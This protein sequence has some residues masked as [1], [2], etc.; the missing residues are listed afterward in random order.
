MTAQGRIGSR[1]RGSTTWV[2]TSASVALAACLAVSTSADGRLGSP[3]S[4]QA[5]AFPTPADIESYRNTIE[6]LFVTDR[7]GTMPGYAPCVMCHTW[8]TRLRFALE[9]P[10]SDAGWTVEQ[11]RKNF[12]VV[13]RLVNTADPERS[14]L[15]LKPLIPSAGGLEHTGGTYWTSRNNAEYTA[16]LQWIRSLPAGRYVPAPEP[17][18]DFE[19]FRSCVQPVFATPREGHIRCSNCHSTGIIGFAPAP[20]SGTTWSDQEAK[21]A[22]DVINRLII[23]G[24]AEQSRFLLKPL[25]PDGGGSYAHNG[26]RRW[27]SRDDP[28][29]R[30]LAGWVRGERKGRSC[31]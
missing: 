22:F 30:M 10:A 5:S 8:Q 7:G 19:F 4:A 6:R 14:R 17:A 9:T 3:A 11:S 13:T 31:S 15:L 2:V 24:N 27:Q 16:V 1:P 29:W 18:L 23:P 12:D 25:H 20:E 26:P 28:E 21:R